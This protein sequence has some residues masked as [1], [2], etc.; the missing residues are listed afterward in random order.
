MDKF[1]N[2]ELYLGDC[3]DIMSSMNKES[4]DVV[5]VDHIHL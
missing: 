3:I 4:V 1:Q 5:V 2:V